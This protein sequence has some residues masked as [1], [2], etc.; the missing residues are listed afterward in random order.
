[1]GP[2]WALQVVYIS[3]KSFLTS[4]SKSIYFKYQFGQISINFEHFD[5]GSNLGL[6]VGKYF[7]KII[8]DIKIEV[9]I[10]EISNVPNF[11]KFR[12]LLILGPIGPKNRDRYT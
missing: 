8:F 3:L 5:F 7:M 11:N 12:K 9:S 10:F 4:K 2:I 1:M 6:T